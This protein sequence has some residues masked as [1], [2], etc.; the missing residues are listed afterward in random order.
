MN[1]SICILQLTQKRN[2][3]FILIC[4]QASFARFGHGAYC[5]QALVG[6]HYTMLDRDTFIPN[7]DYYSLLL[8]SR[9]MGTR[10]LSVQ[11]D[12]NNNMPDVRVYA[13]CTAASYFAAPPGSITVLLINLS[14][15]SSAAVDLNL[16]AKNSNMST[17]GQH[18]YFF[19]SAGGPS[20]EEQLAS[21][22][23]LLNGQLLQAS[24][25]TGIPA[26]EPLIVSGN[27]WQTINIPPLSYGFAVVLGANAPACL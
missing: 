21:H 24:V 12:P 2:F 25:E 9:L 14:N 27:S 18:L 8:W 26:L 4:F 13:H 10:V 7:P 20:I 3:S 19:T 23:V 11:S 22:Q 17:A 16:S 15:S 5:R 6:G 1:N